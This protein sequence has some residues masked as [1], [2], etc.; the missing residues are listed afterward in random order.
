MMPLDKK[1]LT[2]QFWLKVHQK[3]GIEFQ[4]FF[5]QIMEKA[6]PDFQKIRPYGREGDKGNDGYRPSEGIY[7]QAYAP[8]DPTE[9]EADAAE[10]FKD[11]FGKLKKGWDKISTIRELNFVYN[12]KGSGLTVKLEEAKAELRAANP[13]I[14]F[15]VFTPK[16]LE[17]IF[18][19]LTSDE[20]AVLGF[21]IDS[22]NAVQNT[23]AQLEKLD[24]ELDREH[25][26]FVLR[27]LGNVQG[28]IAGQDD[29]SLLLDY[30]ILEARAL[31][32]L[33][34]VPE[35]REKFEG[36][37]KR[38]P[39]DPRAHLYLAQIHIDLE[40]FDRNA[41]LLAEAEKID[42]DFWLLRVQNVI[43]EL[44]LG[45]AVNPATID[46]NTF[47]SERRP[48]ATLY[49]LYG[50]HLERAG[51]HGRAE[52]FVERAIHFNPERFL[53]H[54]AKIALL[55]G[56]VH[57]E[58]DERKRRA[59][60][61]RV[62]AE[63]ASVE[64]K[65]NDGGGLNARSRSLLNVRKLRMH[66]LAES[67]QAL[68]TVTQETLGLVVGCYFDQL[69]EGMIVVLLQH[70]EL[71]PTD[72][73]RL[74][75]YLR[76]TEKPISDDLAKV[77]IVQFLQNKTLLTDGK[78]FFA[79]I[80]KENV[81]AFINAVERDDYEAVHAFVGDDVHFN[82]DLALGIKHPAELRR[83]LVEALPDDGTV[84]K[85]RLALMLHYDAGEL[86]EA[87]EIVQK[88][89]LATLSYIESVH[90]LRIAERKKA[91]DSVIVLVEKILAHHEQDAKGALQGKLQLFTANLHLERFPEVIRIG[92][93]VLDSSAEVALLDADDKEL[94]V[95]HTT[96]AYLRRGDASA[97]DFVREH[98]DDIRSFEGKV[99]AQGEAYLKAGDAANALRSVV[100]GIK[101]LKHPTP[102]QYGM[103]FLVFTKLGN[104]MPDLTLDPSETVTPGSFVK[105][106]EQERWFY[107][108]EGVELDATKSGEGDATHT[109][110]IGKKLGDKVS[111]PSR[112][113]SAKPEYVIEAIYSIEKYILWQSTHQAQKLSAEHRWNAIELIE[114][115]ITDESIDPQ[116]LIAKMEDEAH[117]GADFFKLYCEENVPLALLARSE[118]GIAAAIGHI[119]SQKK[120]FI[121]ATT[122]SPDE[123]SEQKSVAKRLLSGESF[124]L[125]GTSAL[126]LSESGLFR[127]VFPFVPELKVP[128]SVVTL[129]FA[130]KERFDY[131]PGQGGHIAYVDG[132]ILVSELDRE[133]QNAIKNNFGAT[134]ELLEGNLSNIVVISAANK[135]GGFME[136]KVA[137][138]LADACI[139]AQRDGTSVLTEDF[140][141]LKAN[142]LETKKAAPTYCSSLA[143]LRVLYE[144]GKVSF[145]E[146]LDYFYYL[147]A[148]RVRFL[149]MTTDD[150]EKA[151]FGDQV[152]KIVRPEQLRKFNFGLTLSEEYG[153]L[154]RIA[155]D[156][157][158]TFLFRVLV[159]DAV[160][161]DI[162]T[163]I[164]VEIVT[165]FP[166]TKSRKGFGRILLLLTIQAINES[167]KRSLVVGSK[168]RVQEKVDA[169]TE[170]LRA[171]GPDDLITL[172]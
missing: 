130:L 23:R 59:L 107:L 92:T 74:Q 38:Y 82:V 42:P 127:R 73:A 47:P 145:D 115:P 97:R 156:V 120:G 154:P 122:G 32:K 140:L 18:L 126:M 45:T 94:L 58:E 134:I 88:L 68:E 65:F 116:Y 157:V 71:P 133:K 121:K 104:L 132:K 5:E 72:F 77:V 11:D 136:Q 119:A 26:E 159:D 101:L 49:R 3:S 62:L 129:L 144:E 22:R 43:R 89:D 100:E 80:K 61:G 142:E 50:S 90:I 87:F 69:V 138:S 109:A 162:A 124:Y 54:E 46:E 143:L 29:E 111:F 28:I 8:S 27:V 99:G 118:G 20:I 9:K 98:E 34:R 105:L 114:V 155:F 103:L 169:I 35:A 48:K 15:K 13:Q 52:A 164:F 78:A 168:D 31:Q 170:F 84:N 96:Q 163:K 152:I 7:Y 37:A 112:Y 30:E 83:K 93:G 110:L 44:R 102:E 150:L 70:V 91:W 172:V 24:E 4:T 25:G 146:Y 12:E 75:E 165:M 81:V 17:P 76:R 57:G 149:P 131:E 117:K 108:G 85:N 141:Y 51:D 40:E 41:E 166:T 148:Y 19:S 33:E 151:V 66:L 36:I 14:E 158:G 1:Y 125:D 139:L 167:R 123:F 161:A 10:K 53:N 21:D 160:S 60:A 63:I 64:G 16:N 55:E 135:H 113:Q 86:N 128:Q 137:P 39:N 2:I 171:Y 56:K 106:R 153:V 67:Y 147:S 95:V 79:D 6:Y